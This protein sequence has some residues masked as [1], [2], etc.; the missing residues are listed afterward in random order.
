ML[1]PFRPAAGGAG[2]R[3]RHPFCQE[4]R[5]EG[6]W[7]NFGGARTR[8]GRLPGMPV[9][10]F[11]LFG[12][13]MTVLLHNAK[14]SFGDLALHGASLAAPTFFAHKVWETFWGMSGDCPDLRMFM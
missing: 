1:S 3:A 5:C 11:F 14:N 12:M 9:I 6:L 7:A 8:S 2:R 13:V 10:A 4:F